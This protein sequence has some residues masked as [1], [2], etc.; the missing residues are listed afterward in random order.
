MKKED[1]VSSR[2]HVI[3]EEKDIDTEK[4]RCVKC[5]RLQG[6]KF[7]TTTINVDGKKITSERLSEVPPLLMFK[8]EVKVKYAIKDKDG[9]A[10][11]KYKDSLAYFC[12]A[13]YPCQTELNLMYNQDRET[14][15][16][17]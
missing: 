1:K 13:C 3:V 12:S 14:H 4:I 10:R 17:R 9:L 7:E 15:A 11:I 16:N 8:T 6:Y 5:K 2:Y